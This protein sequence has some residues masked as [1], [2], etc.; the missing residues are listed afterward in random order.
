M[1]D[2]NG[3]VKFNLDNGTEPVQIPE[4]TITDIT[5]D[6]NEQTFFRNTVKSASDYHLHNRK[7]YQLTPTLVRKI[8]STSVQNLYN[9]RKDQKHSIPLLGD[10][11]ADGIA[12]AEVAMS[13]PA[14]LENYYL[15]P[16]Q[17]SLNLNMRKSQLSLATLTMEF[18][19]EV[20]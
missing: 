18:D 6:K 20:N 17:S 16:S 19:I 4:I 7:K 8:Q 10:F 3:D 9:L 14:T 2:T 11:D 15:S 1:I 12:P 5:Q 13:M